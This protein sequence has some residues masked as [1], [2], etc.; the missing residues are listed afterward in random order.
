M[1][2]IRVGN[3]VVRYNENFQLY[4]TTRLSNPHYLPETAIL[5]CLVCE[6]I[7]RCVYHCICAQVTLLNF[8]ITP[9]GLE[10]Q[11]LGLIVATE[12]PDLEESR[13]QL[14]MESAQNRRELLETEQQILHVLSTSQGDILEDETAISTLTNAKVKYETLDACY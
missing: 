11:L 10:D 5:V 13:Q 7:V 1:L 2:N 6:N 12:R 4:L 14:V 3:D 8:A 9:K